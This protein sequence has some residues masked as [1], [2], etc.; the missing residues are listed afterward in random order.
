MQLLPGGGRNSY[1]VETLEDHLAKREGFL[2]E[3][4]IYRILSERFSDNLTKW[5]RK[6]Q[7]CRKCFNSPG[8]SSNCIL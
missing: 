2:G 4:T 7:L 5:G 3:A 1:G 8:A 6:T